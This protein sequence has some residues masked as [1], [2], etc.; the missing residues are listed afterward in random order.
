MERLRLAPRADWRKRA[1]A[2]DFSFHTID[3]QPYWVEDAAYA[4]TGDEVDTIEA[5]TGELEAM[6]LALV[7]RTIAAG[8]YEP[9]HLADGAVALIEASWRNGHRNLYG[10]FDLSYTTGQPPKLLE[11]NADTPTSLFEASVVQWEWLETV[12][13]DADQF[14]SIHEKL[15]DAWRGF[16]LAPGGLWFSCVRDHDEDRGTVDY[17]RDTAI[18]AGLDTGFIFVDEI[19]W[20]AASKD[21]VALDET[22]IPSLFKLYPWEWLMREDFAR[23]IPLSRTQ[24]VEPAWKML[25]SNKAILPLLWEMSPGHPNLLEAS[26]DAAKIDGAVAAKPILGR[27]GANVRLAQGG[28][29]LARAS[30]PY[31][32]EPFVYQ[33]LAPLPVFDG[34]HALIGSWVVASTPAGIGMRE[35]DGPITTNASRFVPHLFR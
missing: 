18:Q 11:Y 27:E 13:P 28:K 8:A 22:P 17:L 20:N 2:L 30:G 31:G 9:F 5:A 16:G 12:F 25:L 32:D 1:E 26:F 4:F 24:F 7:E 34:N 10:R 23:N 35:D 21:F 3:G 33:R 15:I 6:C 19:G 29:T 14:N